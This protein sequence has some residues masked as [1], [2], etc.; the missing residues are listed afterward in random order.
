MDRE[1]MVRPPEQN[2]RKAGKSGVN[3]VMKKK[4]KKR[5]EKKEKQIEK[6]A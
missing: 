3:V 5:K 4:E 2:V 1:E 6:N